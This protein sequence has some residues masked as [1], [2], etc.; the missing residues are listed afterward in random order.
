M[1]TSWRW[2]QAIFSLLLFCV[3]YFLHNEFILCKVFFSSAVAFHPSLPV[4]LSICLETPLSGPQ[5]MIIFLFN[6]ALGVINVHISAQGTCGCGTWYN[7]GF[8]SHGPISTIFMGFFLTTCVFDYL[9]FSL[10][11]FSNSIYFF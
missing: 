1:L 6:F 9:L 5:N 2:N 11:N 4:F 8:F 10:A 7:E 3:F